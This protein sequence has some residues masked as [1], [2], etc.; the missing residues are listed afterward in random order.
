MR[1]WG[2]ETRRDD[3]RPLSSSSSVDSYMA[4]MEEGGDEFSDWIL[5]LDV[6]IHDKRLKAVF[7]KVK[8]NLCLGEIIVGIMSHIGIYMRHLM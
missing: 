1:G 2:L 5:K 6:H 8:Y 3:C 4:G 7:R